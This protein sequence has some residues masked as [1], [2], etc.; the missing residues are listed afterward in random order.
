MGRSL[1]TVLAIVM[2]GMLISIFYFTSTRAEAAGT[3]NSTNGLILAIRTATIADCQRVK[4]RNSSIVCTPGVTPFTDSDAA[5]FGK[6]ACSFSGDA[7]AYLLTKNNKP[8]GDVQGLSE[9]FS[10]RLANFF[11]AEKPRDMTFE[12]NLG[13]VQW[14]A[15]RYFFKMP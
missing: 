12:L 9:D 8:P 10:C 11:K 1:L 6:S 4:L 15:N 14:N 2:L 13:I 7:K 3:E 5:G